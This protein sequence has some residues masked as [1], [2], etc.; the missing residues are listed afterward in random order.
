M[1]NK[2]VGGLVALLFVVSIVNTQAILNLSNQARNQQ[3][4]I[5]NAFNSSNR[6]SQKIEST[7]KVV[8]GNKEIG[9]QCAHVKDDAFRFGTLVPTGVNKSLNCFLG[10]ENPKSLELVSVGDRVVEPFKIAHSY[11]VP[12]D[13][14]FPK[15]GEG[16]RYKVTCNPARGG[17][18]LGEQVY[19]VVLETPPEPP[20][21]AVLD[22]DGSLKATCAVT[23][24]P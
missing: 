12:T 23:P 21:F 18:L 11:T 8:F 9:G 22:E 2:L 1:N 19:Y 15:V 5:L 7:D 6:D 10:L 24:A 16:M 13:D 20:T 17:W 14:G 4:S 3:A